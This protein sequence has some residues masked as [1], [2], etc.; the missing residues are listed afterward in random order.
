MLPPTNGPYCTMG[1]LVGR[2]AS[3]RM[4]SGLSAPAGQLN[5]INVGGDED[6]LAEAEPEESGLWKNTA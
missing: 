5:S 4:S 1:S 6:R 3:S 2:P